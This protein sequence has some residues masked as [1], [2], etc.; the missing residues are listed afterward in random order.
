MPFNAD[1]INACAPV[2]EASNR[3]VCA[4]VNTSLEPPT[5]AQPTLFLPLMHTNFP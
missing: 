2:L 4:G 3:V 1:F 5:R